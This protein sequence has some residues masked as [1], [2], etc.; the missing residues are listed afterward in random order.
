MRSAGADTDTNMLACIT[1]LVC[2]FRDA[3]MW[4][5]MNASLHICAWSTKCAVPGVLG[6]P[7]IDFQIGLLLDSDGDFTTISEIV[8]DCVGSCC[9]R[10]LL[11]RVFPCFIITLMRR[12]SSNSGWNA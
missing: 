11:V 2:L 9:L 4:D 6:R 3:Y 5:K 12:Y 7:P 10:G 1:C 8:P